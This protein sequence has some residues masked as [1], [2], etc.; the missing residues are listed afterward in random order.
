MPY[1]L[2]A[3]IVLGPRMNELLLLVICGAMDFERIFI[4]SNIDGIPGVMMHGAEGFLVEAV[5]V[6][7][8]FDAV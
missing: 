1:Y 7:Q 6:T 2:A 8:L 5:N 3:G 4:V